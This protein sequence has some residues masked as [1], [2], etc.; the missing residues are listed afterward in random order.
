MNIPVNSQLEIFISSAMGKEDG[1]IWS[2]IRKTLKNKLATCAYLHP[3]II[4]DYSS[5]FPSTQLFKFRVSQADIVVI[6]IKGEIRTGTQQEIQVALEQQKPQLVYFIETAQASEE[7]DKFKKDIESYDM[8]TYKTIKSPKNI[9]DMVLN[10]IVNN[11]ILHYQYRHASINNDSKEQYIGNE[12]LFEDNILDKQFLSYF[13]NNKNSLID[14]LNLS[15]YSPLTGDPS[16]DN[17]FGSKLLQWMCEGNQFLGEEDTS[18]IYDHLNIQGN[19]AEIIKLRH[20]SIRCYFS[21]DLKGAISKLD[22]AH[23]Q[24]EKYHFNNWLAGDILIDCRN[25]HNKLNVIESKYQNMIGELN[26]L[27]IFPVGDR[28]VKEAFEILEQERITINTLSP[29]TVRFGNTLLDSL[30]KIENYLYAGYVLGSSTHLLVAREKTVQILIGYGELYKDSNLIYQAVKLIILT[31]N[32][33]LLSDVLEAKWPEISEIL[34]I[35]VEELWEITDSQY[36]INNSVMKC[37]IIKSSG[38][39]MESPLFLKAIAFLITYS[40]KENNDEKINYLLTAVSNNLSRMYDYSVIEI[41]LNILGSNFI[42]LYNNI[43]DIL[44]DIDITHCENSELKKL[45]TILQE[46][47]VTILSNNG[48][49]YFIVNLMKQKKEIFNDLYELIQNEVSPD[50]LTSIEIGL[51]NKEKSKNVLSVNINKLQKQVDEINGIH[52]INFNDSFFEINR[53]IKS[54]NLSEM[55]QLLNEKFIPILINILSNSSSREEQENCL[56][57]LIVLLVEYNKVGQSAPEELITFFSSKKRII[58]PGSTFFKTSAISISYYENTVKSLLGLDAGT[59]ILETCIGYK[60]KDL[61]ERSAFSYSIQKYIEFNIY[62]EYTV[63]EFIHLVV[64]DLLRDENFIVRKY[65]IKS[66]LHIYQQSPSKLLKKELIKMTLDKSPNVKSYYI[67]LLGHIK[68][69]MNDSKELLDLF[70]RDASYNIR[71]ASHEEL[72]KIF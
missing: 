41:L 53:L 66:L 69:D 3:F 2:D 27:V 71:D 56:K 40:Q 43:T 54:D 24:A 33:K 16:E 13:G 26:G 38:Q 64:M 28:F 57:S 7:V 70:M 21:Q 17:V 63:P 51:G 9:P 32:A 23:K 10:D 29:S 20:E 48:K 18:D 5:E 46:K 4:E 25:I 67:H 45:S 47:I 65:A 1:V 49:P 37:L 59:T 72:E 15:K 55:I 35:K 30:Q 11:L 58:K 22:T 61:N 68:I 6:L 50:Q 36:C 19:I 52:I 44:S 8:S 39:Y 31:G 14:L 62:S 60:Y 34:A 42:I 12:D